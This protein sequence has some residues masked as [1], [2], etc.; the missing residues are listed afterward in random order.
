VHTLSK[1]HSLAGLRVGYALGNAN[2]IQ[3]LIRVKDSFNSYPLGRVAQAGATAAIQDHAHFENSCRKVIQSRKKLVKELN[4]L[5][6]K[7]L[8]SAANFILASHPGHDAATLAASLRERNIVV[9]H[10]AKPERI[11]Q[12]LRITIGTELQCSALVSALREILG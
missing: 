9:R 7:V 8:P 3:A 1:S 11:A 2:L 6:F 4:G 10:F 5:G 12:F